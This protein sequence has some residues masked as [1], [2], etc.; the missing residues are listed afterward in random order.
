[1][2]QLSPSASG[3]V[4]VWNWENH[5][6]PFTNR[7]AHA[8]ED[9]AQHS[10]SIHAF[11]NC[12]FDWATFPDT[13]LQ[14]SFRIAVLLYNSCPYMHRQME[15]SHDGSFLTFMAST[16]SG[17]SAQNQRKICNTGYTKLFIIEDRTRPLPQESA[18]LL[19]SIP[20]LIWYITIPP[21]KRHCIPCN[22]FC[23]SNG[24]AHCH[25]CG[26]L[27]KLALVFFN[28]FVNVLLIRIFF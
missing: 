6:Y 14:K 17:V 27:T 3:R 16:T 23:S 28:I 4:L 25:E 8:K 15:W 13:L 5:A 2:L 18:R 7:G 9:L 26:I 20:F 12:V 22:L 1:M 21:T 24:F 10:G 19:L 11:R